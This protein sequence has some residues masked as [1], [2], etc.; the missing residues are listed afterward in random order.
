MHTSVL[1]AAETRIID[2]I[3]LQFAVFFLPSNIVYISDAVSFSLVRMF[4]LGSS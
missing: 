3:V 1:I 4:S 2:F